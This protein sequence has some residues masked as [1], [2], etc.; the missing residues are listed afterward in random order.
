MPVRN[1]PR[2]VTPPRTTAPDSTRVATPAN[3][4]TTT[5][6]STRGRTR[7]RDTF[8]TPR[9][10]T[11]PTSYKPPGNIAKSVR[12]LIDANPNLTTFV[13]GHKT[14]EECTG[15]GVHGKAYTLD[16]SAA[17]FMDTLKTIKPSELWNDTARYEMAFDRT[18]G[19]VYTKGNEQPA[20][21]EGMVFF[22]ELDIALGVKIPVSFEIMKMD[23]ATGEFTFSYTTNNKSQG[24]QR[25]MIEDTPTGS[26]VFH[27]TRFKSDSNFRDKHFY[28][29]FHEKLLNEF[30]G[31]LNKRMAA[32]G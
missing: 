23:A 27:E 11:T 24:I 28:K 13:G 5:P 2:V 18:T 4:G 20:I 19:K 10:S 6:A 15:Y 22:L 25:L 26:K 17:K 30:Y 32:G 16:A 3:T 31:A 7:N 12:K 1:D 29:P 8:E 14:I 21:R 9:S